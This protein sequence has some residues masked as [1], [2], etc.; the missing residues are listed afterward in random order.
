M[1]KLWV[2]KKSCVYCGVELTKINKTRDHIPPKSFFTELELTQFQSITVPSC[3]KCNNDSNVQD[4]NAKHILNLCILQMRQETP[5]QTELHKKTL[6]NNNRL[7]QMVKNSRSILVRDPVTGIDEVEEKIT[8]GKKYMI[9]VENVFCRIARGLHWH[10][11]QETL[12]ASRYIVKFLAGFDLFEAAKMTSEEKLKHIL[13]IAN[14]CEKIDLLSG[15]FTYWMGK[16]TD[17]KNASI[18]LMLYRNA[19]LISVFAL[20][21]H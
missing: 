11:F 6:Q 2:D 10:H 19:V 3:S 4:E 9:D 12:N 13:D 5:E 15:V 18:F 8:V 21:N 20:P 16:P 7:Y 17:R 1:S 14:F